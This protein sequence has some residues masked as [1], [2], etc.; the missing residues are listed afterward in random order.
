MK[1]VICA[2]SLL[3]LSVFCLFTL[4]Q[5]QVANFQWREDFSY[6][7]LAA[8]QAANWTINRIAGTR[9]E[10]G[11]VVL[12]GVGGDTVIVYSG[13]I[14]SGIYEWR[15]EDR[16]MWLGKG[17]SGLGVSIITQN[18]SYGFSADGWY[19]DFAF[20][21]DNSKILEFG[22]YTERANEWVTLAIEK[23]GNTISM[24][25]NGQLQRTYTES[26]T[27]P[28]EV[29]GISLISP[30]QGD[31]L[32]DYFLLESPSISA[33]P[34]PSISISPTPPNGGESSPDPIVTT[35]WVPPPTNA[36]SATIAATAIV[37]TTSTL[38][39]VLVSPVGETAAKASERLRKLL[40]DTI[41]KWLEGYVASKR[42]LGIMEKSGSPFLPTSSELVTYA[43][44]IVVLAL[45]FSF[46]K[47]TDLS[48]IFIILPTVLATSILVAFVKTF[49]VI[50]FLRTK[51]VWT[52]YKLW[53]FGL[54]VFLITTLA[55]K[56]PFSSPT[57]K[58][59]VDKNY[60]KRLGAIVSSIEIII[61]LAFAA[62]FF[63]LLLSGL[64][65]IGST[66]LAMCI[67]AAF[68]DTFPFPPM[69]GKEIFKLSKILWVS[70]FIITLILYICWL[71]FL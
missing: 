21:R 34:F 26:D 28:S 69:S 36:V 27:A 9:L 30:W 32:Y 40:P 22:S 56:V 16:A 59:H 57:R 13:V 45:S 51:G 47:V 49:S 71:L 15:V 3:I 23:T 24:Y 7:D 19:N 4:V 8:M 29:T 31:A 68:F 62:V 61:T 66:G 54:A 37:G 38:A 1:R 64:T 39:S 25:F 53:Y 60:T 43:V 70:F 41:K 42:K 55:F 20:Y 12:D 46:V 44:S 17:H 14:P 11:G 10:S 63:V 52:E 58:V 5:S 33:S 48:Q 2:F 67:I 50:A 6:A 65:L 18:H 35:V